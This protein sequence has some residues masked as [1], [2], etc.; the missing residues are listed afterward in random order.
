MNSLL[1][2]E[3]ECS[4]NQSWQSRESL[5][6]ELLLHLKSFQASGF[7]VHVRIYQL[8]DTTINGVSQSRNEVILQIDAGFDR[9]KVGCCIGDAAQG[10]IYV[11]DQRVKT[12]QVIVRNGGNVKVRDT[13]TGYVCT[14]RDGTIKDTSI[15]TSTIEKLDTSK[16]DVDGFNLDGTRAVTAERTN[17]TFGWCGGRV[18][19]EPVFQS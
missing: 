9:T 10:R 12:S 18:T 19:A 1:D 4:Q 11:I 16:I 13:C 15:G 5:N 2:T 7:F 14:D 8:A 6:A 17:D 3:T